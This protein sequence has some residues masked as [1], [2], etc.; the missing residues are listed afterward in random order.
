EVREQFA[1]SDLLCERAGFDLL[2]LHMAHGYLLSSFLTPVSNR[3]RDEY[4]GSLA[5]RARFPLEVFDAVRAAWPA[6]KPMSVRISATDWMGEAGVTPDEAVR[7]GEAFARAGGDLI[8][9]AAGQT[10]AA[11]QP[12]YGRTFQTRLRDQ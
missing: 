9:V 2:E 3:R 10:R 6:E 5:N 4:G 7:I 12:G 1:R 8:D 11:A